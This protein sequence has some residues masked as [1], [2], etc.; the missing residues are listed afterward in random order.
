MTLALE[1][2]KEKKKERDKA[3]IETLFSLVKKI[4]NY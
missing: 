2:E 4:K 1:I 3:V